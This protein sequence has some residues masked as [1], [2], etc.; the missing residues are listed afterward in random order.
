MRI[1]LVEDNLDLLQSL[2]ELIEGPDREVLSCADAEQAAVEMRTGKMDILITDVGLPGRSGIDL[3]RDV[4]RD[5]PF[6]WVVFCS[7]YALPSQ[8]RALGPNVRFLT[9]PFEVG[10]LD[11]VLDEI[12]AHLDRHGQR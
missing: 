3:A 2:T 6:Q 8:V 10:D 1:L 7:G 12:S 11:A 5:D 9:K 4:L